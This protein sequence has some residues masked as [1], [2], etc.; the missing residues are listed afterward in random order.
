MAGAAMLWVG[1]FG[2]NGGSALAA[3]GN[4]GMAIVA[5]HVSA[6]VGAL[7]WAAI[8]WITCR[9][10]SARSP[11]WS[12][13]SPRSLQPGFVGPI[14]AVIIGL[15]GYVCQWATAYIKQVRTSTT[16]WTCSPCTACML[17]TCSRRFATE[18]FGGLGIAVEGSAL[19]QF[20]VQ[21]LGVVAVGVWSI[22]TYGIAKVVGAMVP[23]R[24]AKW[25]SS[26]A[27]TST[28]TA[29]ARTI[30]ELPARFRGRL[31]S[32]RAGPGS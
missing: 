17:G 7:T 21:L 1:W 8:E 28:S 11:G 6:S 16:R 12:R 18:A 4:A 30:S 26:K 25:S 3:N 24:G 9:A 10:W 22:A 13:A 2:F 15:G 31:T 32:R 23:L 27:S 19:A 14:G 20:G 29:S 5:T